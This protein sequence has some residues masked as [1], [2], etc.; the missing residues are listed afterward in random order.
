MEAF[1]VDPKKQGLTSHL[2]LPCGA[3]VCTAHTDEACVFTD[4]KD[5]EFRVSKCSSY[6]LQIAASEYRRKLNQLA[7]DPLTELF[8]PAARNMLLADL[9]SR[10]LLAEMAERDWSLISV[11]MDMNKLKQFNALGNDEGGDAALEKMGGI[12]RNVFKRSGDI[13]YFSAAGSQALTDIP[14]NAEHAVEELKPHNILVRKGG[15]EMV[16][17]I[18]VPPAIAP[19][20]PVMA[21]INPES[22]QERRDMPAN[23]TVDMAELLSK[24]LVSALNES[25]LTFKKTADIG[26]N[27]IMKDKLVIPYKDLPNGLVEVSLSAI[28]SLIISPVPRKIE[29]IHQLTAVIDNKLKKIKD[30]RTDLKTKVIVEHVENFNGVEFSGNDEEN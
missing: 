10:G 30:T 17:Y 1:P 3:E 24:R 18:F 14:A 12:L 28:V 9:D 27:S 15:D 21:Y 7:V 22:A 20:Q 19:N 4:T 23:P 25:K 6:L 5:P 8:T 2:P 16:G 13:T 26:D 11:Y 29:H